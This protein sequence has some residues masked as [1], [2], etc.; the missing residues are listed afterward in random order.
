[1]WPGYHFKFFLYC[2]PKLKQE[3]KPKVYDI[4][5]PAGS[6]KP[7]QQTNKLDFNRDVQGWKMLDACSLQTER[8]QR[9]SHLFTISCLFGDHRCFLGPVGLRRCCVPVD[10]P[11]CRRTTK[12]LTRLNN[13]TS[14]HH[15]WEIFFELK[16]GWMTKHEKTMKVGF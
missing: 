5:Q 1:M 2:N 15:N 16:T 10:A 14:C 11:V 3:N 8:H 12:S 13:I 9:S 7:L 4:S 6:V